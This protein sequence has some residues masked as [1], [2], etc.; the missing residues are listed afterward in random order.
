MVV[1]TEVHSGP[2]AQTFP[3]EPCT[4]ISCMKCASEM[5]IGDQVVVAL[6]ADPVVARRV[7]RSFS[8]ARADSSVTPWIVQKTP[9]GKIPLSA[10]T[11]RMLRAQQSATLL[12]AIA[13]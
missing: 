3:A 4:V 5:E 12:M 1:E 7:A 9:E 6:Q 2:P 11:M 13:L 10:F 8:V